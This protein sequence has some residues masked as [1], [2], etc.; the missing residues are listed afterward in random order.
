MSG[1]FRD[2]GS[3]LELKATSQEEQIRIPSL[4]ETQVDVRET[5]LGLLEKRVLTKIRVH[6]V[7]TSRLVQ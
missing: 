2:L 7:D 4:S 3:R 5:G 6:D 1:I